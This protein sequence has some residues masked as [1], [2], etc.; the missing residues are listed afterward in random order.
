MGVLV[1]LTMTTSLILELKK[2]RDHNPEE[3]IACGRDVLSKWY[4]KGSC[5][6]LIHGDLFFWGEILLCYL[7]FRNWFDDF[8]LT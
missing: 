4:D 8:F 1:A 7:G 5:S 2:R 3:K 6:E